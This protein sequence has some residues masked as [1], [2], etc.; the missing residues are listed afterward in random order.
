MTVERS[1][2]RELATEAPKE[3][4]SASVPATPPRVETRPGVAATLFK[5]LTNVLSIALIVYL[6]YFLTMFFSTP[7]PA[8]AVVPE[9]V[10]AAA[11]KIQERQ[12]EDRKLLTTYGPIDPTT[13]SLRI[14]IERAMDLVAAESAPRAVANGAASPTPPM[15]VAVA[16]KPEATPTP[17]P[18]SG[19]PIT[20]PAP[21]PATTVA[22]PATTVA[23][24]TP[25]PSP[26]P[27][28]APAGLAPVQLYKAICI[29]CHDAD[30]RG[31]IVRK[32]MPTIPD[33]T[34]AKWQAT[35]TDAELLHSVLE[36]KGQ[37][38][39]SMK[40]KFA[41]AK[42][43]PKDMVA[44]MRSFQPGRP[45]VASAPQPK[46]VTPSSP[47]AASSTA[48]SAPAPTVAAS[49]APPTPAP[50]VATSIAPSAPASTT[51]PAASALSS[52][53]AA[54]AL[55]AASSEVPSALLQALSPP[56][57]APAS[58]SS[59]PRRN[60]AT[61][62]ATAEKLR[63]AG[64]LY[65]INCVACHGPDGRGSLVRVAM[66]VIPDFTAREWQSTHENAQ[67]SVSIMEGKGTLMPPWH[68][69][70]TPEQARDLVAYVRNFGPA[71]LAKAQGP[72]TDFGNRVRELRKQWSDLDQQV[73]LLARP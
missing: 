14:P 54:L 29:A 68:G 32:A 45:A 69:K 66:P 15:A 52:S 53:A 17:K 18:S 31:T 5:G 23:I 50:T 70:V 24:S 44:F 58:V 65:S 37:F 1:E 36:G 3:V 11:K 40:D 49:T 12:A 16:P 27:P 20:G 73:Q 6:T 64:A 35:R 59:A 9:E 47:A 39:L 72:T 55:S 13:K 63:A 51:P 19:V 8:P 41:L 2:G 60:T 46:P 48:P 56:A 62:P 22:P 34:D 26:T 33:L 10:R 25:P 71:D 67:L 4:G 42:T 38:M 57:P 43:D 7:P 30:G 28:P 61:S 21:P